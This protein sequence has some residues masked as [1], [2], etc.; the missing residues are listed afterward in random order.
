MGMFQS[1]PGLVTGRYATGVSDKAAGLDVSILA[2]SGDRALQLNDGLSKSTTGFQSSPGL[3][4]G[5][6][7]NAFF[8]FLAHEKFQSS[9]GLVTGRYLCVFPPD[10]CSQRFQS[11]PGLVTG[12]YFQAATEKRNAA[13][14][15]I[16][17]RSGDRALP[18][19]RSGSRVQIHVSILARSGDRALQPTD[20]KPAIRRAC[21][22]PRP[23]W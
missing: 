6:Y 21:F 8:S 1:S 17:A 5:R 19:N 22:N 18:F 3:V 16:L 9:P 15:S 20:T 4:T 2:R 7:Q 10:E 23:V 13:I 11:S 14:V 12:R